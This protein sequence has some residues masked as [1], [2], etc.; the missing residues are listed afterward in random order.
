[1][2]AVV[3]DPAAAR[4]L[5]LS[6]MESLPRPESAWH[7][8]QRLGF[9]IRLRPV[10]RLAS[11]LRTDRETFRKGAEMDA[12]LAHVLRKDDGA[13]R[14]EI[15]MRWLTK[16]LEGAAEIDPALTR[17]SQFERRVIVR[18]RQ[19]IDG[20]DAT[21]H[22]TLT[23]TDPAAFAALLARGIGRHLTY[24]YGML[25]LRPPQKAA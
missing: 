22:G 19:R 6:A 25:M 2:A 21:F 16:R 13:D 14:G 18:N 1:M 7:P 12:F 4:V 3:V 17:L 20:P 5:G 9:D 15:Y 23:V 8:G 10:V 24:G 11:A